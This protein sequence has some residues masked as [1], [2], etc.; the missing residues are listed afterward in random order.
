LVEVPADDAGVR[1]VHLAQ[2][3]RLK[4]WLGAVEGGYLVANG[5]L[6]DLPPGSRL[7]LATGLFTWTPGLAYFGTYRLAFVRGGEQIAV[8]VTIRPIEAVVPGEAAIRMHVDVPIDGAAVSGEFIVAG[9][10]LDPHTSFGSGIEAVHVWAQRRDQPGV[11][12]EFL[13]SATLGGVRPDVAAVYGTSFGTA[14]FSLT[15]DRLEPGQY[16]I[17]AYVWNR[18]TAR[19]EDARTVAVTVR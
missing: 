7:D 6:R 17:T 4:L 12:P 2:L 8:D 11:W 14:G 3:G 18:R 1:H 19:W 13:G 10:A 16:D 15:T 9:W 5:T